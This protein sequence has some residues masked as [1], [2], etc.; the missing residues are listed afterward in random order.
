VARWQSIAAQLAPSL[1]DVGQLDDQLGSLIPTD[2]AVVATSAGQTIALVLC[3]EALVTARIDVDDGGTI[4]CER[5]PLESNTVRLEVVER[6]DRTDENVTRA[7]TWTI[8]SPYMA[9]PITFSTDEVLQSRFPSRDLRATDDP[10]PAA[11]K[12]ARALAAGLGWSEP[13]ADERRA[14][15]R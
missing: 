3:D 11:E 12:L 5:V 8:H 6:I 4:F 7:R 1:R 13:S 14:F 15:I 2:D 10:P 9:T